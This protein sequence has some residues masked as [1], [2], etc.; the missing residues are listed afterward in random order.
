MTCIRVFLYILIK[1]LPKACNFSKETRL[2]GLIL[3]FVMHP[4]PDSADPTGF[5]YRRLEIYTHLS[6]IMIK[7]YWASCSCRILLDPSNCS[8]LDILVKWQSSKHSL[9]QFCVFAL[10]SITHI[11]FRFFFQTQDILTIDILT[12]LNGV[13]PDF[14]SNQ[15]VKSTVLFEKWW[16]NFDDFTLTKIESQYQITLAF[17]C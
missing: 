17:D 7:L 6:G 12:C 14:F 4:R 1:S 9:V 10:F 13:Y 16:L 8:I 5:S 11:V 3:V 2:V 15:N